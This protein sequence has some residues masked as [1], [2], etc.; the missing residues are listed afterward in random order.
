MIPATPTLRAPGKI[1]VDRKSVHIRNTFNLEEELMEV[2]DSYEEEFLRIA[3]D[4]AEYKEYK[5]ED[6]D[7]LIVA[8]GIV[9]R[10][11]MT[12]IDILRAR[13]IKAGLFRP[14]TVRPLAVPALRNACSRAKK[15]LFTESANGQLA[16]MVLK[17]IYG[18]TTPYD[19]LY[20]MGVGVTGDDLVNKVESMSESL[21]C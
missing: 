2:L 3:P 8:H 17:E 11:A 12:A 1:G 16:R 13:G 9:A 19:T 21:V 5:A 7:I 4:I 20:K 6:C 14:I 18:C 10:S 15:I